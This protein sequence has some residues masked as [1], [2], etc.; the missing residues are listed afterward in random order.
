MSEIKKALY[1]EIPEKVIFQAKLIAKR[2]DLPVCR[3]VELALKEFY[4]TDPQLT[5]NL[6]FKNDR[7][8]K[9]RKLK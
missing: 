9:P 2:L 1:V 7:T 3:I 6:T 5:L 4:D 8:R